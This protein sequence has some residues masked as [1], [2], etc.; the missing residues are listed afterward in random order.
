LPGGR[1]MERLGGRRSVKP[2]VRLWVICAVTGLL[3][4]VVLAL[5]CA[6]ILDRGG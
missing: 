6:A 2:L 1:R 3:A 5:V 4:V